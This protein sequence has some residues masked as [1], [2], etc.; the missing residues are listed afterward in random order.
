[1]NEGRREL[2]DAR[3]AA[4]LEPT[5]HVHESAEEY[6]V[7]VE[8][9]GLDAGDFLVQ[10]EGRLLHV[11]GRD[12]RTPGADATFEFVFR[13]PD[14]VEGEGLRAAFANGRL[15]IR[16]PVARNGF[17]TIEIVSSGEAG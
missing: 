3:L 12:L 13:L 7:D 8:A 10:V 5:A 2:A 14:R 9:P 1:V 15:V 6:R 11:S 4:E 16:A 17:R